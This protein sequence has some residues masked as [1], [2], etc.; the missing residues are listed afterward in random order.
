MLPTRSVTMV[1]FSGTRAAFFGSFLA[2]NNSSSAW[3]VVSAPWLPRSGASNGVQPSAG[4]RKSSMSALSLPLTSTLAP[5]MRALLAAVNCAVRPVAGLSRYAVVTL[6]LGSWSTMSK[7]RTVGHSRP[8]PSAP[9]VTTIRLD[10]P[11]NGTRSLPAR[12]RAAAALKKAGPLQNDTWPNGEPGMPSVHRPS[13][14]AFG[15]AP[16]WRRTSPLNPMSMVTTAC[17][18]S[19]GT[20][21]LTAGLV[22]LVMTSGLYTYSF[23]V[24]GSRM[25]A[26]TNAPSSSELIIW[27]PEA[28]GDVPAGPVSRNGVARP[29][30]VSG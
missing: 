22:P 4:S 30:A 27:Q 3:E 29:L 17:R 13:A 23:P 14:S 28:A 7:L 2:A 10:I 16:A 1:S 18:G 26:W 8:V 24:A 6:S 5:G 11:T 9:A 25:V 20:T 15:V 19:F 21:G 12:S